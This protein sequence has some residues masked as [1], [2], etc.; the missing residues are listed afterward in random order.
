MNNIE[1]FKAITKEMADLYEKKN[2]DYGNSFDQS[3]DK[4][5]LIAAI[6]RMEDKLN[7]AASLIDK[8]TMVKSESIKDTLTDLANYAI[9]SRMWLEGKEGDGNQEPEISENIC[10]R[11]IYGRI[12]GN[13]AYCNKFHN[14]THDMKKCYNFIEQHDAE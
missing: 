9:M 13:V 12:E 11:C 2:N 5:G 6:V 7:R 14:R 10:T 4:H 1:K 3:C 8:D